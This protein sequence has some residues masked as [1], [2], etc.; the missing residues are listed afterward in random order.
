MHNLCVFYALFLPLL[1][2]YLKDEAAILRCFG[3]V[4]R[5]K[6]TEMVFVEK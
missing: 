2:K 1:K 3:K 6:S 5:S 4:M